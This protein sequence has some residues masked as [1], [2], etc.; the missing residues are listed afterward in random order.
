MKYIPLSVLS[1]WANYQFIHW[2]FDEDRVNRFKSLPSQYF[3]Y[4]LKAEGLSFV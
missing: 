3:D 2:A 1:G 4:F